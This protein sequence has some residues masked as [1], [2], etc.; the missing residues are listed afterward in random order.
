MVTQDHGLLV[1]IP[2][3]VTDSDLVLDLGGWCAPFGI[4]LGSLEVWITSG[5]VMSC[6]LWLATK[7]DVTMLKSFNSVEES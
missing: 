5:G 7:F 3:P 2:V 6:G 4:A 1:E